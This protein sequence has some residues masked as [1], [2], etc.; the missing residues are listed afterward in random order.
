MEINL[1]LGFDA[2]CSLVVLDSEFRTLPVSESS[3][4]VIM[5]MDHRATKQADFINATGHR[6]LNRVGGAISPEMDPPKILWLKENMYEE[7]YSKAAH[8]FSLPDFLVWKATG[9]GMRSVCTTTCKWL[10][11]SPQCRWDKSF[12]EAIDLKELTENGCSRI[13]AEVRKP[14]EYL[15]QLKICD[16]MVNVTGLSKHVKIGTE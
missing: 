9:I 14:F 15:D 7:N 6:C 3:R 1:Y 5:W 10:Y 11:D 2:T 16:E 13:G 12:W 4:D 8:F